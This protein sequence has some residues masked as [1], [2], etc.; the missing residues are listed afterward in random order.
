MSRKGLGNF[1]DQS[2][3]VVAIAPAVGTA[4]EFVYRTFSVVEYQGFLE[5]MLLNRPPRISVYYMVC[6]HLPDQLCTHMPL[7]MYIHLRI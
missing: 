3:L 4:I 6:F 2:N 7:R 1:G 5:N